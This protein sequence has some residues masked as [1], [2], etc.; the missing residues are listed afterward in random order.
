MVTAQQ[1]MIAVVDAPAEH[2]VVVGP[3]APA[4]MASRFVKRHGNAGLGQP[5]RGGKAGQSGADD[6]DAGCVD[7]STP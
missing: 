1:Q 6:V 4:G 7:H 5:D 3:A 2:V